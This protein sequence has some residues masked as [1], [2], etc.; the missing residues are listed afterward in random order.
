MAP[1]EKSEASA[2]QM[3]GGE[4]EQKGGGEGGGEVELEGKVVLLVLVVAE[5]VLSCCSSQGSSTT[6]ARGS[7][8]ANAD[9][10]WEAAGFIA[11]MQALGTSAQQS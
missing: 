7:A 4:R 9:R 11:A 6:Q 2:V 3:P 1:E 10:A 8:S 5:E